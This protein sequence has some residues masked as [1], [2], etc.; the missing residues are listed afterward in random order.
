M[1]APIVM[2]KYTIT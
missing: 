2:D 1:L